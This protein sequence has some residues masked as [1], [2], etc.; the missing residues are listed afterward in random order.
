LREARAW[1][2]AS[3]WMLFAG[4]S[5][6]PCL[7]KQCS[8]NTYMYIDVSLWLMPFCPGLGCRACD[9]S[10]CMS[11]YLA[12]ELILFADGS[13]NPRLR[14]QCIVN[15]YMYLGVS[16]WLMPCFH[17]VGCRACQSSCRSLYLACECLP[18]AGGSSNPSWRTQN[19]M[20]SYK[21]TEV[22]LWLAPNFSGLGCRACK[23]L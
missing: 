23:K 6:N 21:Y 4:G 17:V 16:P 20:N 10:S 13:S 11:G 14:K 3:E 1:Y 22:S 8:I 18:F 2:L 9:L 15:S 19:I 7:G 12:S 5:S